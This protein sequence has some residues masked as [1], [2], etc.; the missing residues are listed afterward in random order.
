MKLSDINDEFRTGKRIGTWSLTEGFNNLS[1]SLKAQF[2]AGVGAFS[3]FDPDDN[4][5]EGEHDFGAIEIGEIN[6]FWKIDYYDLAME[7]H[8]SD[9][10]DDSKTRRV[11][12]IM[13]AD[14]Y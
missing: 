1:D 3:K 8:S 12:T 11:I 4:D 9:P 10:L 14:E 5:P 13:L 7:N 2:L 6:V